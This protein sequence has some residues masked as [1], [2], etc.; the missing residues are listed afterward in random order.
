MARC[1]M[2]KAVANHP[3]E[4]PVNS[5]SC[6]FSM[7]LVTTMFC[8]EI[9]FMYQSPITTFIIISF[10][11]STIQY[12]S[13]TIA[14]IKQCKKMQLENLGTSGFR[15]CGRQN[16]ESLCWWSVK[17]LPIRHLFYFLKLIGVFPFFSEACQRKAAKLL[18][19]FVFV[20]MGFL[21][22]P[23]SIFEEKLALSRLMSSRLG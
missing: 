22:R 2:T 20:I 18:H 4:L 14:C 15:M 16:N 9:Y 11:R 6:F 21:F 8:N 7:M 23:I 3:F 19:F 1:T 5:A 17:A 10:C 12:T 13:G